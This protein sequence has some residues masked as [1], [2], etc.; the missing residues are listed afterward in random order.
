MKRII[1]LSGLLFLSGN[2]FYSC[3]KEITLPQVLTVKATQITA[4]TA[5]AGGEVIDDGNSRKL[6]CGVCWSKGTNPSLDGAHTT[7]EVKDGKFISTMTNLDPE[8]EYYF[9]AYVTNEAGTSYGMMYSFKTSKSS[10][11]PFVIYQ[12]KPLFVCPED[13]P[14]K[15]KWGDYG[16]K[17]EANS[18]SDGVYNSIKI[19][20]KLGKTKN[21][22]ARVCDDL[23][24]YG[25]DD[26]Y[27]PSR[28]ELMAIFEKKD[29]VGKFLNSYYWT[30]TEYDGFNA[31][32]V[33]FINGY[34]D[35]TSKEYEYHV[36]CVR[37]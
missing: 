24:A 7:D 26:W 2:I 18:V 6:V 17:T 4:T 19:V 20:D 22:A 32:Y 35:L 12:G 37:K 11:V 31:L 29:D 14:Y 25:Y 16:V 21:Y 36:R 8:T 1:L 33:S 3:K 28:D 15:I 23:V 5:V 30:S 13:H 34:M 10:V 9:K 27:L